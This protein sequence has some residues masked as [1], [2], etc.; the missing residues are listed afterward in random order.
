MSI[1]SRLPV[2]WSEILYGPGWCHALRRGAG[3]AY[4][5]EAKATRSRRWCWPIGQCRV[6]PAGAPGSTS[7]RRLPRSCASAFRFGATNRSEVSHGSQKPSSASDKRLHFAA[8]E[9]RESNK[10]VGHGFHSGKTVPDTFAFSDTFAFL[11]LRAL[12]LMGDPALAEVP[13]E[14]LQRRQH[15]RM[16]QLQDED[17][18]KESGRSGRFAYID[19]PRSQ[20]GRASVKSIAIPSVSP[21]KDMPYIEYP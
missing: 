10:G 5:A 21:R 3:A 4:G 17:S 14:L 18:E 15:P 13:D 1:S 6:L 11:S 20:G 19:F 8:Q 16:G 2:T 9:G 7:L 12:E